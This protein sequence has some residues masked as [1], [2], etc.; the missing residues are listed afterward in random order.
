M[1]DDSPLNAQIADAVAQINETLSGAERGLISAAAYQTIA[2]AV[3][4]GLQNAVA[5]QQQAYILRNALTAAA[6]SAILDGKRDDADALLKL[7]DSRSPNLSAEITD[8]LAALKQISDELR[9]LHEAPRAPRTA[10]QQPAATA[11]RP[12]RRRNNPSAS[13]NPR[14]GDGA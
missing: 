3:V 14:A 10:P 12:R 13:S 1:T 2:Q 8:L 11:A 5:Q 9:K 7:A 4:L 6:A